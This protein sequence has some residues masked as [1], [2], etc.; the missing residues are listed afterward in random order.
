[1][2]W[3]L[4]AGGDLPHHTASDRFVEQ[5]ADRVAGGVEELQALVEMVGQQEPGNRI[6]LQGAV[7]LVDAG[8][9]T[10]G[11]G[12]GGRVDE[13]EPPAGRTGDTRR[14]R[15]GTWII[16]DAVAH[17]HGDVID[18]DLQVAAE[19]VEQAGSFQ[20]NPAR[21][22]ERRHVDRGGELQVA[23]VV[24]SPLVVALTQPEELAEEPIEGGGD[25]IR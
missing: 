7:D 14:E 9:D 22:Q 1:M 4:T 8:L 17:G 13:T 3:A 23:V 18:R 20:A 15:Q 21:G 6:D 25:H 2:C 16:H 11:V 10:D 24:A 19:R 12:G 5:F